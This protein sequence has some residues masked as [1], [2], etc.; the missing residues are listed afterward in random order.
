MAHV[1]YCP[2]MKHNHRCILFSMFVLQLV[3]VAVVL[4]EVSSV[5]EQPDL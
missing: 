4:V 5:V 1:L 2:A 3:V